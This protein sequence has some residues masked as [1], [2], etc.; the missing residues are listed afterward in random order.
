MLEKSHLRAYSNCSNKASWHEQHGHHTK[1]R[2]ESQYMHQN[3]QNPEPLLLLNEM[4]CAGEAT[5]KGLSR[6]LKKA[7]SMSN[8]GITQKRHV[9]VSVCI[10]TSKIL[11]PKAICGCAS[12]WPGT[13]KRICQSASQAGARYSTAHR[14][15]SECRRQCCSRE[16]RRHHHQQSVTA[17]CCCVASSNDKLC[18]VSQ[19]GHKP[20]AVTP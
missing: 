16:V 9:K 13:H 10:R 5:S 14:Q 11:N 15:H 2:C 3:K 19:L 17:G 1:E 12:T 18:T 8:M 20:S 4:S 6:V 7:P